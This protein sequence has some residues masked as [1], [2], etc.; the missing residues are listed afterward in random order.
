MS[1]EATIRRGVRN[2]RY[3]TVPNHVFEDVRLSMEARWLLG[4]LLSK[5]DNWTVILGDIARRGGCG[6]D[7]ARKIVN[8]LVKHGYADKEQEREDGRFGKLSLVIFDE[9]REL[10]DSAAGEGV[11]SLPQTENPSTVMPSTVNPTLVNTDGLAK[12]DSSFERE[13]EREDRR[14]S[15][16]LFYKSF[17]GWDRFDVSPKPPMLAEWFKLSAADQAE[18]APCVPLFLAECRK[19]GVKQAC[20]VATFIKDRMWVPFLPRLAAATAPAQEATAAPF[21]KLWQA[22]RM[23]QLLTGPKAAMPPMTRF[24]QDAIAAGT[25][26]GEALQLERQAKHGWPAVNAMHDRARFGGGVTVAATLQPLAEMMEQVRVGTDR[27]TEWEVEHHRR[28]WPWLPAPGHVE[29]V[30]MPAG[31]PAGLETFEQ[32]VRGNH[33]A[34]GREAAE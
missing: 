9:P 18:C 34:G 24:Q 6:R 10:R 29:W 19:A 20:A 23:K 17:K 2:A 8:E 5:P 21:G 16:A 25:M 26:D 12:P 1:E 27:W 3:T 11:A 28:G 13:R 31:G 7:K 30:W 32:A 14:R 22:A 15:E 4:Y 33:D